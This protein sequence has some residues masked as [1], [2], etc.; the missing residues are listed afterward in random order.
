MP[1][2]SSLTDG[3]LYWPFWLS[4]GFA[5][6]PPGPKAG[7][8]ICRRNYSHDNRDRHVYPRFSSS[9]SCSQILTDC[10]VPKDNGVAWQPPFTSRKVLANRD[11]DLIKRRYRLERRPKCVKTRNMR[12]LA[13]NTATGSLAWVVGSEAANDPQS[14]GGATLHKESLN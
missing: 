2:L 6:S 4:I 10:T 9:C 11:K 13:L 12:A 14:A 3:I 7:Q 5:E 8:K 1:L